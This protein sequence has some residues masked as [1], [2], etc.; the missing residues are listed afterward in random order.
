MEREDGGMKSKVTEEQR[1]ARREAILAETCA[2]MKR[3]KAIGQKAERL[4]DEAM[5]HRYIS[6]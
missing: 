4:Y 1:K 3:A 5:R 6:I 2:D